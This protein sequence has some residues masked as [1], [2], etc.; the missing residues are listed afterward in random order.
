MV[1]GARRQRSQCR[2][3]RFNARVAAALIV[4]A[5]GWTSIASGQRQ[6]SKRAAAPVA[7][8]RGDWPTYGHDPGGMRF[9]PLT[10][11]T[12]ANA[13]RLET[14]WVYHMK[15]PSTPGTAAPSTDDGAAPFQG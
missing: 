6:A 4:C 11:I 3:F 1:G 2:M 9:S 13:A 7:S 12:P 8:R 14:A 5:V 10:E 15:P